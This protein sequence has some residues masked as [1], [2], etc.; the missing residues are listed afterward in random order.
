[1]SNCFLRAWLQTTSFAGDTAVLADSKKQLQKTLDNVA[2]VS[3][4]LGMKMNA[5]KTRDLSSQAKAANSVPVYAQA[6]AGIH[7]IY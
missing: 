3:A 5:S 6:V 2:D 7:C 1:M 4:K